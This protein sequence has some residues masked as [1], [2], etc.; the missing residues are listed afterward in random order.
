MSGKYHLQ[1]HMRTHTGTKPWKCKY[2]DK[3]F[4]HH[5]NRTRHEI[6]H[7]ASFFRKTNLHSEA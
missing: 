4:A 7:T 3:T 2:C 6:S 1:Y 5:A